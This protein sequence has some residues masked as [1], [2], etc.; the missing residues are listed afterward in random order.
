MSS[1]ADPFGR[2]GPWVKVA[3]I[4]DDGAVV[5][6]WYAPSA[7]LQVRW[8]ETDGRRGQQPQVLQQHAVARRLER[9][10][11]GSLLVHAAQECRLQ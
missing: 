8:L 10:L 7:A 3:T 4:F 5:V 9:G 6:D 2:P 11:R 1:C